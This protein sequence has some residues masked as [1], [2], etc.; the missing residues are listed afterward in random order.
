MT[1]CTSTERRPNVL[2]SRR[3]AVRR[4]TRL[5]YCRRRRRRRRVARVLGKRNKL[6]CK[7]LTCRSRDPA[8]DIDARLRV[9]SRHPSHS[10]T[11][12]EQNN[13][14]NIILYLKYSN[15]IFTF[16]SVLPWFTMTMVPIF[17]MV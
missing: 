1:C 16:H 6:W 13:N 8:I 12:A 10:Y 17:F 15:D 4:F 14:N 7:F 3:S 5:C 11:L 2:V 9:C